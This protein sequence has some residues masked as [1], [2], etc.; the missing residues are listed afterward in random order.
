M[1]VGFLTYSNTAQESCLRLMGKKL[2]VSLAMEG[3]LQ[4]DG[5]QA[6]NEDDDLLTAMARELVT[7]QGV[8]EQAAEV[9]RSLQLQHGQSPQPVG[10]TEPAPVGTISP[11][12]P[13]ESQPWIESSG[14]AVQLSLF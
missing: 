6:M 2:L 11:Q 1:R 9:W 5:L 14:P 3:K 4:A 13:E 10:N 7:R 8:G 12:L